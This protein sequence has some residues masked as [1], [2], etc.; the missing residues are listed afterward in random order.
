MY[1]LP[2]TIYLFTCLLHVPGSYCISMTA[3]QY[4]HVIQ[5]LFKYHLRTYMYKQ[6]V[7]TKLCHLQNFLNSIVLLR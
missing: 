6:N 5:L 3:I 4:S 7:S 2:D 1:F